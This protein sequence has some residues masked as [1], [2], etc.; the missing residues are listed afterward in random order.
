MDWFFIL[1][2][3]SFALPALGQAMGRA[4]RSR[5]IQEIESK[6]GSRLITLVHHQDKLS[7]L[8]LPVAHFINIEDSERIL[9][10]IHLTPKTMPIDILLHTPGGLVLA[11]HQVARALN[12]HEAKVTVFVPHYAMS[13]GTL[14]ALSADEIV[15]DKNAVLGP[16]DPQLGAMPAASIV[17]VTGEKEA[18]DLDD[19]T[20]IL[21]DISQKAINQMAGLVKEILSDHL[22]ATKIAPEKIEHIAA[23]LVSGKFSHDHAITFEDATSL[24]LPVKLGI[25]D[26]IYDLMSLYPVS[27]NMTS[28]VEYFP[29]PYKKG[30]GQKTLN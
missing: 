11:A 28:N 2:F 19:T 30:S 16:V 12:R 8:G 27:A 7:L 10:A 3:V 24:G 23:E 13:G 18:D 1:I 20:L 17:A 21:A 25:P 15:M 26:E 6:R 4:A 14:L 9:R 5:L 22:P 29:L